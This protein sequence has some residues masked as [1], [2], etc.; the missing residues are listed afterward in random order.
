MKEK[1]VGL[2]L[3]LVIGFAGLVGAALIDDQKATY[4]SDMRTLANMMV[5]VREYAK[6]MDQKWSSLAFS[7][8]EANEFIQADIDATSFSGFTVAQLTSCVTTTQA[9]ETWFNAGHD[10]NME[11]IRQ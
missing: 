2:I 11:K 8:G 5:E 1:I 3:V 9:Y 4:L 10:D 7:S 6:Q